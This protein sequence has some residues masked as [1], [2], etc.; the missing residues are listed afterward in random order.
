MSAQAG[1]ISLH[2]AVVF[3][4]AFVGLW[5]AAWLGARHRRGRQFVPEQRQDFGLILA[6]TLSAVPAIPAIGIVLVLSV[7]WFI[8][9]ARAAGN[10]VGNCVATVVI[11]FWERDIDSARARADLAA[12]PEAYPRLGSIT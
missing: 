4:L 11:A 3:V 8:G 10:L 7:D 1:Y 2:P 6:A 9:M 12:A 5:L